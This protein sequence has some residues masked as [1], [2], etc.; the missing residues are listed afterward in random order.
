MAQIQPDQESTF[1]GPD[2][3]GFRN[4]GNSCLLRLFGPPVE[5]MLPDSEQKQADYLARYLV[6]CAASGRARACVVGAVDLP[7]GGAR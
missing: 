7:S 4:V 6:L 5:R 1:A 3:G 2:R